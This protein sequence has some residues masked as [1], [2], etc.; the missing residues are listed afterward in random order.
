MKIEAP[1]VMMIRLTTSALPAGSTA[2]FSIAMPTR[3]TT[4]TAMTIAGTTG[5]PPATRKT[6]DMPPSMMNSPCAKLITPLAL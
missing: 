5:T 2:N 6:V 4:T 3:P 1:M